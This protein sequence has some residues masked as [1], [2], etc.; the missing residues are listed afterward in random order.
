[1]SIIKHLVMSQSREHPMLIPEIATWLLFDCLY[2]DCSFHYFI[3]EENIRL[4]KKGFKIFFFDQVNHENK[5]SL[6]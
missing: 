3:A 5:K 6:Q 1:M 2:L 4:E